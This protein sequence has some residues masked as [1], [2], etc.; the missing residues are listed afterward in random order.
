MAVIIRKSGKPPVAAPTAAA[1]A[2]RKSL[3]LTLPE[4]PNVPSSNLS[5]Y[6]M[7]L[8]GAKKIGKTSLASRFPDAIFLALEPG[9]KALSVFSRPVHNY[10]ELIEY[11]ELLE[12]DTRFRTIVIDTID[13]AY[14]Y[15]FEYICKKHLINHPSEQDDFGATWGEIKAEF[16]KIVLKLMSLGKGVIFISHDTERAIELRD[17]TKIERVQPTMASQ[18]MGVVEALVDIIMNY[19]YDG[20]DRILRIEGSHKLVA[21]CRIEE[22]FVRKGGAPRMP[23]DKIRA[24]HMGL[25]SQEAYDNFINAFNNEQEVTDPTEIPKSPKPALIIKKSL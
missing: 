7:L 2:P 11:V 6:T 3:G 18:A 24:I 12:K 5:D 13:I 21:G 17:G 14:E 20:N 15:C 8:F 4:E 1:V 10:A 9:T 19:S 25:T 16:K 23:G 22:H